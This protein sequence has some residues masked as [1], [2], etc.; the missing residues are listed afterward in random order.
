MKA[1]AVSMLIF[2]GV[3]ATGQS[4]PQAQNIFIITLDGYRWQEVFGG[5]D[6]GLVGNPRYVSDTALLQ[7]LYWDN[8]T[9]SRRSL[10]MPF[11]WN[12][13]AKKGQLYG[14]RRYDNN[15]NVKNIYKFSYPGY[16]EIF[17]GYADLKFVPNTPVLNRNTNILE[18]LNAQDEYKGKC[19]AFTSWNIFPHILNES[20]MGI[21]VNSGYEPN[22]ITDSNSTYQ[23]INK[24]QEDVAEKKHTRYDELTFLS[25]KEYIKQHHPKVA[26]IGLG[27]T[28]EFAHENQYDQYLHAANKADKM[29]AELWYYVQTD[30]VYKNNTTFI[31][32]T[33]HGRG[34]KPRTWHEHN[35]LIKGSGE[36]WMA[37]LGPGILPMGEMKTEG[38][39]FQKQIA[40]TIAMLLGQKFETEHTV[41]EP[42][43]LPTVQANN[44][45]V[46][47]K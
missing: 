14:N 10:L 20:R 9:A 34:N 31:I 15:M 23:L 38:R 29:I 30:P 27:E 26:F 32:T 4:L 3:Y 40:S 44:M 16:N 25:A 41:G 39:I 7:Q 43:A 19:V 21:E 42:I 13:I 12:V 11:F 36:I 24:V 35:T 22:K 37:L 18:F 33:D 45:A 47:G 17:T 28:D 8:D 1:L 46:A 6:E 5:A 2:I